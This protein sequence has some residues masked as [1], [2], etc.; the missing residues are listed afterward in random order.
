M[1]VLLLRV[2]A[3]L[4]GVRT[5]LPDFEV[6]S[7]DNGAQALRVVGAAGASVGSRALREK[8]SDVLHAVFR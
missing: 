8:T 4:R 7:E 1:R 2:D 5:S 3:S 6:L